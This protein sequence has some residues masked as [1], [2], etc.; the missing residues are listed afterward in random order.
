MYS[1]LV[2]RVSTVL[3]LSSIVLRRAASRVQKVSL[4]RSHLLDRHLEAEAM[5][6]CRTDEC[7]SL[8]FSPLVG[9]YRCPLPRFRVRVPTG[10][11][12]C[13]LSPWVPSPA[14]PP[15]GLVMVPSRSC[16]GELVRPPSLPASGPH[17]AQV[18]PWSV[19]Q[20][21]SRHKNSL[22]Q[23]QPQIPWHTTLADVPPARCVR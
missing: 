4:S 14:A 15:R 21:R 2:P 7:Q 20:P 16:H 3:T 8:L 10:Q 22:C 12:A 5:G 17:R 13:L 18:C 11:P 1:C 23:R 9:P 19:P 6:S